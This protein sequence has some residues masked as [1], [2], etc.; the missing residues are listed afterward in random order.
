M[1]KSK[2]LLS[3][4]AIM[5][6]T[7]CEF[8]LE[9]SSSSKVEP[10]SL[11]ISE[12]SSE[13]SV[14][15]SEEI[16]SEQISDTSEEASVSVEE[17]SSIIEENSSIEE[18]SSVMEES[19]S[20]VEES[21]SVIEESSSVIE[22][23][24]SEVFEPI[25]YYFENGDIVTSYQAGQSF[26]V[27]GTWTNYIVL[28]SNGKIVY[29]VANPKCGYG[30]NN[31]YY[32]TIEYK[33]LAS[34][35]LSGT[36]FTVP[37][38]CKGYAI[39]YSAYG[40]FSNIVSNGAIS[41]SEFEDSGYGN[42]IKQWNSLD[43]PYLN[44]NYIISFNSP[45]ITLTPRN[46]KAFRLSS[47]QD[48]AAS[49]GKTTYLMKAPYSDTYSISCSQ[50]TKLSI[51]D[52]SYNLLGQGTSSLNVNL[53]I[54]KQ[55]YVVIESASS[56]NFTLNVRASNHEVVLPYEINDNNKALNSYDTS[57]VGYDPLT[58]C[59]ISYN[60]RDDG[61]GLYINS[62][63]PEALQ[64]YHLNKVFCKNQIND[65][66]VFFTFEHNNVSTTYYYGYMVKN[67]SNEDIYVTVKNLG[68]HA[69]GAGSWLG[70]DEWVKFYNIS[71]RAN[72][73]N[74][75]SSQRANFNAYYGFSNNYNSENRQPI[76]YRIPKNKYIYVIG[77]TTSDAYNNINVFNSANVSVNGGCS[78]GA[79]LF[80]VVGQATGYFMA[81]KSIGSVDL[82]SEQGYVYQNSDGES[83]F[84]SQYI[85]YDTCH[86]VVDANL[87]WTFNDLTP[88]GKL[89]VNYE[90]NYYISKTANRSGTPFATIS[91]SV[92]SKQT[93]TGA[94]SWNT[95]INPNS[96]A[97][98]VGTDM[99][100][101]ICKDFLTNQD[102]ICDYL[103]YDGRGKHVNIGNWMVDYID[104][105][106]LVN[107]GN[108]ERTF[109]Y[110]LTHTG[111]IL[112]FVRDE[113]GFIDS[114][115]KPTY[116]LKQAKSDYGDG[117]EDLFN[118]EVKI[119]A[120]SVKRFSVDYNLLA[121]AYG[122]IKHEAYL[123]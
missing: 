81:Y 33:D 6:L 103:H 93:F 25:Y 83:Q 16:S 4:V 88:E 24:S 89:T 34:S 82:N 22:E 60:K 54:N 7:S 10:E 123:Q 9:E 118:Y 119:P 20:I 77:G 56:A 101:Y 62:N 51:Y 80:D 113:Q 13:Q 37:N 53:S 117:F 40:K 52:L 70:E 109:T 105:I 111:A 94:T 116:C 90:N 84:G 57:S 108:S 1:K 112:A 45:S 41:A 102:I 68:Y 59:N 92:F 48:S 87:E 44:D 61:N 79:V 43:N 74:F 17:S 21:S 49:D 122:N 58:A 86:G 97:S 121:N 18:S 115:Y 63:N 5:S 11:Q 50:A 104:T 99:T 39:S 106:T 110:K 107:R 47:L 38:Y 15:K 55:V 27:D 72:I 42:K 96:T 114:S 91:N 23:S 67:T 46:N 69:K 29:T 31:K 28:D 32:S 75:T 26:D 76:T 12:S 36:I 78:N 64:S 71:F 65:K 2:L 35:A 3:L 85:G 95:H 8:F 30:T 66:Q 120:H 19:S 73:D 98:A 100:R 14:S